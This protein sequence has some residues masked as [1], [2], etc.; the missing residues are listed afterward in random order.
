MD[1]CLDFACKLEK[2]AVEHEGYD[3]IHCSWYAWNGAQGV[4]G[5]ET[6]GIRNQRKN[7]DHPDHSIVKIG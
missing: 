6:E 5:K 1:K 7:W 2:K 4:C 3:D